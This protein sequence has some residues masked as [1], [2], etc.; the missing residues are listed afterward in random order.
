ML[1]LPLRS[2]LREKKATVAESHN[3]VDVVVLAMQTQYDRVS[4]VCPKNGEAS[5]VFFPEEASAPMQYRSN[6]KVL[7]VALSAFGMVSN[8][9]ICE[10][11]NQ[12]SG[13]GMSYGT[14]C[15]IIKEYAKL[16]DQKVIP[17]LKDA[18]INSPVVRF[19]ETGIRVVGK[20][21]WGHT[22]STDKITLLSAHSKRRKDGILAAGV[23]SNYQGIAVHDCGDSCQNSDFAKA[24]HAVC[25]AHVDREPKGV[26]ENTHQRW[27][28]SFQ[29]LL[30][31]MYIA[32]S[33]LLD[34]GSKEAPSEMIKEF[35]NRYSRILEKARARNPWRAHQRKQSEVSLRRARFSV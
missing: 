35:S 13:L 11:V 30:E 33:K 24:T 27:A 32:K 26:P 25:D 9:R 6:L 18:V 31:D 29:K 17:G 15:D 5:V 21:A 7:L 20:V 2:G 22:S 16:C 4:T 34:A 28:K 10:L 12:I 19:D 3:V 14:V 1:E 8:P 23:L